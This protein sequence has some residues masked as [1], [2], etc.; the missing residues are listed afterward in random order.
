MLPA[1]FVTGMDAEPRR[2]QSATNAKAGVPLD[3]REFN[4]L[5]RIA[6]RAESMLDVA[7]FAPTRVWPHGVRDRMG[8]KGIFISYSLPLLDASDASTIK[9]KRVWVVFSLIAAVKYAEGSDLGHIAFT[10]ID[11]MQGERWY[12]DIDIAAAREIHRRVV[13]GILP[14]D[15][16]YDEIAAAWVKITPEHDLAVR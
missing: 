3:H 8:R 14:L 6:N 2:P 11:G 7:A 12:Y 13:R 1:V 16:G 9:T 15:Q 10:D 5:E 4:A